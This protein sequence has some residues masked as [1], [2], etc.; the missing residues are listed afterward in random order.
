M[1]LWSRIFL[2]SV[3]HE[4]AAADAVHVLRAYVRGW[5]RQVEGQGINF[6]V[7]CFA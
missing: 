3:A 1:P 4:R 7:A 2:N 6:L 5:L